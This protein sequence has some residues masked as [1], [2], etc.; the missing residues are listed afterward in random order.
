M[1]FFIRKSCS[2]KGFIIVLY[3][4]QEL[5]FVIMMFF[6]SFNYR[7]IFF[8]EFLIEFW[9]VIVLQKIKVIDIKYFF[10]NFLLFVNVFI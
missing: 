7:V 10:K 4:I 8:I 3:R 5:Y 6:E 9:Y 2:I 1:I